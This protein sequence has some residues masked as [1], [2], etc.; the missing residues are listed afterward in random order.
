VQ[1]GANVVQAVQALDDKNLGTRTDEQPV[2][3]DVLSSRLVVLSPLA[4]QTLGIVSL[5]LG[6]AGWV[7]ALLVAWRTAGPAGSLRTVAWANVAAIAVTGSVI[8]AAA[9]LR[10]VRE[11][12]HPWYAHAGRFWL[13]LVLAALVALHAIL[14]IHARLPAWLRGVRDPA[15]AWAMALPLWIGLAGLMQWAAPGAA[16]LWTVPLAAAGVAALVTSRPG[17]LAWLAA[18]ACLVVTAALWIPEAHAFLAFAVP[19]LGRLGIVAP[20]GALPAALLAA[21]FMLAVPAYAVASAFGPAI[22]SPARR[23]RLAITGTV[24]TVGLVLAFG[25]AYVAPAYTHERPLWRYAQYQS[26]YGAGRAA[27]EVASIEPGL[28]VQPKG[29]PPGWRLASGP[30]LPGSPLGGFQLPFAFRTYV[31]PVSPPPLTAEGTIDA[32]A[33]GADVQV[34]IGV[35]EPGS[36]V[37]VT[38][39]N[40]VVPIRSSLVGR[41]REGTWT[42]A[43]A[44]APVGTVVFT[45]SFR[46]ADVPRLVGIRAGLRTPVLPG[47]TE[48]TGLPGW[49]PVEHAS[50]DTRAVHLVPVAWVAPEPALR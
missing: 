46:A 39:P 40:G 9:L 3:F 26:D 27:W 11:V 32:S 15:L 34:R 8:G 43:Y 14:A 25:W 29:A 47:A 22:E 24:V 18:A 35:T 7:R 49:L 12:Y 37:F 50:W 10:A 31:V 1:A 5:V 16:F 28:D 36:L 4:G 19:L 17:V 48:Q 33:E 44:A 38:L 21:G 23:R 30:L 42:A 2:F 45:A 20:V 13:L 41:V 6:I